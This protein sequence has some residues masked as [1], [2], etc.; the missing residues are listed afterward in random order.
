MFSPRLILAAALL[1]SGAS[2]LAQP[3]F[4]DRCP[5]QMPLPFASIAVPHPIDRICGPTGKRTSPPNIQLQNRVKNDFCSRNGP[6]L[7]TPQSLVDLQNN[8]HLPYG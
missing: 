4:P 7:V 8:T 2:S 1:V 5:D 3:A 6:E